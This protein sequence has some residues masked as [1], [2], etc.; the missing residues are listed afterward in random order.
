MK[1]RALLSAI[2]IF[3]SALI[4]AQETITITGKVRDENKQPLPGATV[5]EKGTANATSTG[6]DGSFSIAVSKDAKTLTVSY[7]GYINREIAIDAAKGTVGTVDLTTTDISLNQVVVSVSRRKEKLLDA[8]ASISVVGREQLEL[9]VVTTPVDELKGVAGVDIM[10]TGLISSNVTVRG[11]NDIFSGSVLNV[12]DNRIASVP[13]LRVNAY[14]LVP[15]STLDYDKIEVVR[16]PASA[17]Y[18]PNATSGVIAIQTK[19]PLQQTDKFET[20][21]AMTSG[22]TVLARQ[23][24]QYN[25]N[26][27]ISGNIVNPEFRHSGKLLN[28]KFG[29]KISAGYFQG[30]DY[31]NYDTREP[32]QG[33][34]LVFGSVRNGQLFQADTLGV[35]IVDTSHVA[36]VH[37]YDT[38]TKL[39]IRKFNKNFFIRKWNADA[40]IDIHPVK[41]ITI[42]INGGVSS[43]HNIELTGLGAGTAGGDNGGWIYWYL[44]TRFKWKNLFIQYFINSSDA[45]NTYLIPQLT[46]SARLTYGESS[47]P[48]PYSVQLLI[49]KSKIHVLQIQHSWAP[50]EK[51]NFVYGADAQFIRPNTEG[52][53]NGLYEPIDAVNTVGAYLQGDYE[54]LHW[55]KLVAAIRADYS[56]ILKNVAASPRAALVFKVA[57]NQDIRLTYNRAFD[58]PTTLNQFLDLAQT[59]LPNGMYARGIGNPYGYNYN[60]APDGTVEFKTATWGGAQNS[61]QWVPYNSTAANVSSMDSLMKFMTGTFN[62][63]LNNY[64]VAQSLVNAIFQ[65]ISGQNGTVANADHVALNLNNFGSTNNYQSSIISNPTDIKNLKK[66]NNQYTQTLELGYKGLLFHKLS[67]QV[68]AYWTRITNYVSALT[69]ASEAVNFNNSFLGPYNATGALYKNLYANDSS[70]NKILI[71]AGLDGQSSLQNSSITPSLKGSVYDEIV[72]LVSQLPIGAITPNSKYVNS[73]YILTY[74]NVGKL[75]VFG[76]DFG[77]QYNVLET[78]RHKIV[79]GG[80]LSYVDKDKFVVGSNDTVWL[81]APQVKASFSFNHTLQQSG[82]SYGLNFRYQQGYYASSSIYFGQVKPMYILDAQLSYRLKWYKKLLLSINVNNVANYQ[83]SAFPGAPLMGTQFYARAQVTF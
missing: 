62:K 47:P 46:S 10:R 44:Q 9:N 26:S 49:D 8:P 65:G 11:F 51:L 50:I 2:F 70:L 35:S 21:I 78:N 32:Y 80:S 74:E 67:I 64:S 81:N 37:K 54:P 1:L 12:V 3:T 63:N 53:I 40:R 45:G 18:G 52:T 19:D 68:D 75:D 36:G 42:T 24:K 71:N 14:Q 20:T 7:I 29:Y 31:P 34:S 56:S 57:E 15:T 5:L 48:T 38:I 25:G 58:Q 30:Q 17:L 28:G 69:P 43:S 4:F 82:F 66:I 60:Y 83:W 72:V 41:D 22:F 79:L 23:Y 33:D 59:Q 27:P 39:D 61:G 16:G 13:S 6:A 77:F 76:I 55:L 73:D